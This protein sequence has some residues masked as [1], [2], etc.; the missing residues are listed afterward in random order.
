MGAGWEEEKR[1]RR[2]VDKGREMAVTERSSE[3]D[4]SGDVESRL[5][6]RAIVCFGGRG[7]V[8]GS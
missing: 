1:P 8:G 6:S 5:F 2:M 7:R 4:G 3:D